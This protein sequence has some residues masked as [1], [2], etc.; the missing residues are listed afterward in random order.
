MVLECGRVGESWRS[1]RW[2]SFT[3]VTPNWTLQLPGFPYQGSDPDG[4]LLRDEVVAYLERYVDLFHPPLRLGVRVTAV[5][6]G[7]GSEGY[8]V[9]AEGEELAARNVVVATGLLE[10]PKIPALSA[11]VPPDVRQIHSSQYRNP[12]ALPP[13]AVLV[14]GSGQSGCQIA[15]ELNQS[16]RK[17]YL[18][19][20]SV[21]RVPRRY[22]G[23]DAIWWTN[24]RG[25]F[26]RTVEMLPTP[27]AKFVAHSHLSGKGPRGHT[28]NLHQFA[29]DGVVLLGHLSRVEGTKIILAADL[30]ESLAKA[31]AHAANLK[32]EIDQFVLDAGLVVP[33]ESPTD[34]P[35]L[36][37]GYGAEPILELDMARDGIRSIIWATGYSFDFSWVKLPVFDQD[38]YPVQKRGVTAYPGLYFLGMAWLHNGK[39]GLL[40]GVGEDASHIA[41][42][43]A[44]RA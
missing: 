37:D 41:A 25:G 17:V 30:R 18:C 13:G 11:G 35:T 15:E 8:L 16:G 32:R 19:V 14:V 23:K 29:R 7:P 6:S 9:E 24:Q 20:G 42:L 27:R 21:G 39:S 33:E 28:L 38:G 12:Q 43:I 36:R 10:Q 3:L 34:D 40:F 26:D 5:R 2:D 22:R 44:A 31:D 4:F 1:R